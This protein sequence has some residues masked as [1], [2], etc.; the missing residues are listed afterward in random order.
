[1]T[2][3]GVGTGA[4]IDH[5]EV[6]ANVDDGIEFF[7]GTVNASNLFVWAQGDDAL[8]ID[9]AYSGTITNAMVVLVLL[10]IML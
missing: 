9:Q 1:M 4:V 7:G 5:V 3:G 8:D 2:L 6:V 10:Q